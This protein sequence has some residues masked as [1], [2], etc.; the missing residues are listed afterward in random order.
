MSAAELLDDIE[1]RLASPMVTYKENATEDAPRLA[2][3]VAAVLAMHQPQQV[4]VSASTDIQHATQYVTRCSCQPA[5]RGYPC[6]TVAAIE[7][8]LAVPR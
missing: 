6:P 8:A 5:W 3:A 4:A 1:T 2:N 7:S